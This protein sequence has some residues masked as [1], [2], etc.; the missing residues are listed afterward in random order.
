M[1]RSRLLTALLSL[2]LGLSAFGQARNR[3]TVRKSLSSVCFLMLQD[4]DAQPKKLGTGFFIKPGVIATSLPLMEG[5]A[6]GYCKVA[7]SRERHKIQGIIARDVVN[8]VVFLQTDRNAAPSM[9]LADDGKVLAGDEITVLSCPKGLNGEF[10]DGIVSGIHS[11]GDDKFYEITAGILPAM[12]GGPVIDDGGAAIGMAASFVAKGKSHTIVI[13]AYVLEDLLKKIGRPSFEQGK[14]VGSKPSGR[15][16]KTL[17][18]RFG[19]GMKESGVEL[20]LTSI[21]VFSLSCRVKNNLNEPITKVEVFLIVYDDDGTVKTTEEITFKSRQPIREGFA[22]I[23]TATVERETWGAMG[24][25][26]ISSKYDIRIL[27]VK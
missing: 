11:K 8:Q 3:A 18:E 5:V 25:S 24:R 1:N 7:G 12:D 4:K 21:D 2:S 6:A 17:A 14:P 23:V 9:P 16:P 13:P 19:K 10:R 27:S 20:Q 15:E 26:S 22:R